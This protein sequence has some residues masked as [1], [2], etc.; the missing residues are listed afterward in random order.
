MVNHSS[1]NVAL[2]RTN[3]TKLDEN[4]YPVMTKTIDFFF[5]DAPR[6]LTVLEQCV[7]QGHTEG[8]Y[9]AAH[10]IKLRTIHLG[11][12]KLARLCEELEIISQTRTFAGSFQ[13]VFEAK[14]EYEKIKLA[15]QE[16]VR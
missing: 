8:M 10:L 15:L 12:I 14:T 2:L 6:L 7:S 9:E 4:G 13:L 16:F 3:R 5:K 11:A 1:I